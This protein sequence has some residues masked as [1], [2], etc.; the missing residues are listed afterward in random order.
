MSRIFARST[1]TKADISSKNSNSFRYRLLTCE[2]I[3]LF[4]E[5]FVYQEKL[6]SW[7]A[8]E[9]CSAVPSKIYFI[10]FQLFVLFIVCEEK[11]STI[12]CIY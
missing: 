4:L 8:A 5:K 10:Y 9:Q 1:Y 7:L 6:V 2:V 3:V 12:A 11:K